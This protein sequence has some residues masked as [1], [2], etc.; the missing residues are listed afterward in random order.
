GGVTLG[1]VFGATPVSS[2]TSTSPGRAC[3]TTRRHCWGC[4]R[5]TAP[6]TARGDDRSTDGTQDKDKARFRPV[7]AP[8][9]TPGAIG[10]TWHQAATAHQGTVACTVRG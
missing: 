8:L 6:R 2:S 7:K 10:L 5:A 9:M 1:G 3:E 4:E